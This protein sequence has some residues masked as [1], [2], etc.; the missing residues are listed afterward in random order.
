M[1]EYNFS[2]DWARVTTIGKVKVLAE[3]VIGAPGQDAINAAVAAYIEAHPGALSPLSAA[4]KAALLQIAE[5][6]AYID[7]NGESYYNT[8]EA[9]LTARALVSIAAVYTQSGTVYDT[10]SLDSLKSDLV[11]TAY[12]DDGTSAVIASGYTLSGELTVGTSTI[13]VTLGNKTATFDVTVASISTKPLPS[14]YTQYDYIE[15]TRKSLPNAGHIFLKQYDDLMA[16]S[17]D[18]KLCMV[19]GIDS[20]PGVAVFGR[21]PTS[22]FLESFAVY[23]ANNSNHQLDVVAH[24]VQMTTTAEYTVGTPFTLKFRN[25]ATSPATVQ[26]D[27]GIVES[28]EWSDSTTLSAGI[29]LLANTA[30]NST[31]NVYVTACKQI[32][33]MMFIDRNGKVVG[34]FVPCVNSSNRIGMYDKVEDVFYT[35][36]TASYTTV[37]N[38]NCPYSVGNWS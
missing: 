9:A 28:F 15:G 32:G 1:A 4:T 16:L 27:D 6:V 25:P 17:F 10:D 29:D 22:T 12:Y 35:S 26:I 11:V 21:R 7:E 2:F 14:G 18:V 20:L 34:D 3:Q 24:G 31:S 23:T 13:T 8:L 36:S 37:G 19:T 30:L 5:K 33:E 38:S